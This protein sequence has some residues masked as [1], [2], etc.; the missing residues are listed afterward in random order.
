V[1]FKAVRWHANGHD[2]TNACLQLASLGVAARRGASV[3]MTVVSVAGVRRV[4]GV[5]CAHGI[6]HLKGDGRLGARGDPTTALS[7][8]EA[9]DT[10]DTIEV[11]LDS[12]EVTVPRGA[13]LEAT[14]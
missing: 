1:T 11:D 3:A 7:V 10:G 8:T 5:V 6:V 13:G 9:R 14:G 4:V 12:I 2:N